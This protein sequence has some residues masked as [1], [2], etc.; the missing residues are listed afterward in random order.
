MANKSNNAEQAALLA[1]EDLR[2]LRRIPRAVHAG[3]LA[4]AGWRAGK[5]V[6]VSAYDAAVAGFLKGGGKHVK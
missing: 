4:A 3:A 6:S 2:V 5:L 1:V